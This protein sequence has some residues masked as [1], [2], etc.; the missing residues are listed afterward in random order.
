M[1]PESNVVMNGWLPQDSQANL[2][3]LEE[4]SG[5]MKD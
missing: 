1:D 3:L 4:Y 5:D 2:T